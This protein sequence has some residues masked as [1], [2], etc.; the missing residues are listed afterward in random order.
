M[1]TKIITSVLIAGSIIGTS[2]AA[3]QAVPGDALYAFK[4]G[5]NESVR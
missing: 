5:V 3:E 1:V 4:V 2:F